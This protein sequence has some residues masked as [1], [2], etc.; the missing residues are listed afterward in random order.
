MAE[1][2]RIIAFGA[3]GC[4]PKLQTA[5]GRSDLSFLLSAPDVNFHP[6]LS[7]REK[8]LPLQPT[9]MPMPLHPLDTTYSITSPTS[10]SWAPPSPSA[11]AA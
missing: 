11:C 7:R 10:P 4:A 1:E 9:N 6:P 3:P 2:A 8:P 5:V